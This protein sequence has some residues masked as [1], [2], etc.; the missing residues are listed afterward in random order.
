MFN[1]TLCAKLSLSHKIQGAIS[2]HQ[3]VL[4]CEKYR[5][6]ENPND[7]EDASLSELVSAGE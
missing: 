5:Y 6:P 7:I 2:D 1:W 4:H 3:A